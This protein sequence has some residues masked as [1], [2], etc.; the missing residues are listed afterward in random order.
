MDILQTIIGSL[1]KEESRSYKLFIQRTNAGEDRKDGRLFDLVKQQYPDY[2]EELILKKLYA[3]EEKNSLYRLKNRV[4]EDLGKTLTLLYFNEEDARSVLH[5]ISLGIHFRKKNLTKV[6]FYYLGKA[7]KRAQV[8]SDFQ[9]LDLIYSEFIHLSHDTMLVNPEEYIRKRKENQEQLE[10]VRQIDDILAAIIYRIQASQNL[11]GTDTKI[12]EVLQKTVNDFA[13][14][15]STRYNP[16]LRQKIYE[17]V[18][19]IL[20]QKNDFRSLETYLEKTYVEFVDDRLFSKNNHETKLQ[21]LTYMANSRF[22]LGM[23]KESLEAAEILHSAMKEYDKLL[24]DKYL[25]FYYN[26]LVIN[27]SQIQIH[28]A[29]ATLNEAKDHPVIKKLPIYDVFIHLNLAVTH[30]DIREYKTALKHLLKLTM[31]EKFA[32]FDPG[33]RYKVG[34]VELM[35]RLESGD[36]EYV[37]HKLGQLRKDFSKQYRDPALKRDREILEIIAALAETQSLRFDKTL[38]EKIRRFLKNHPD[39]SSD[40]IH[41]NNWLNWKLDPVE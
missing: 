20:L 28:K 17:S 24:Y 22:K 39:A 33:F 11:G 8:L 18:S 32:A 5:L 31:G 9:L 26:V 35:I 2:D 14:D 27:Y 38:R 30:F 23:Y 19:K 36:Q 13:R 15:K 6:A 41:Y 25:A 29:I 37:L 21:M 7:E 3:K 34:I 1:S 16:V 12:L 10:Q 4:L 40:I